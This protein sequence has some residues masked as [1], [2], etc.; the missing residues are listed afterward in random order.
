M[1]SPVSAPSSVDP[2]VASALVDAFFDA[3]GHF[4]GE[5]PALDE[6]GRV[7][8][9]E[10]QI[11]EVEGLAPGAGPTETSCYARDAWLSRIAHA[12]E[13]L[14]DSGQG[15]FFHEL[16][17]TISEL[18]SCLRVGSIVEERVTQEARVEHVET[19][20]CSLVVGRV[21]GEASIVEVRVR[22]GSR[23]PPR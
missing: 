4:A 1:G 13:Q 15:H 7:L 18:D 8:A 21:D 16:E 2:R 23:P 9:P 10:A 3:L 14:H 12:S 5:R 6:L 11:V 17:R 20:F 19:L 22:R